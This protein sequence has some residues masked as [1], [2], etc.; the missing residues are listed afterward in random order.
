MLIVVVL[1]TEAQSSN[2]EEDDEVRMVIVELVVVHDGVTDLPSAGEHMKHCIDAQRCRIPVE[3]GGSLKPHPGSMKVQ[4]NFAMPTT[5]TARPYAEP[6]LLGNNC[7]YGYVLY[8]D[9]SAHEPAGPSIHSPANT[10][11]PLTMPR[12]YGCH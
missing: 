3:G 11:P 8:E 12:K 6:V 9:L 4:H 10:K 7:S 2:E 5:T 1:K